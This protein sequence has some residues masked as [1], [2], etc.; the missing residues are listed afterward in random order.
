MSRRN[1][2]NKGRQLDGGAKQAKDSILQILNRGVL[3]LKL[4]VR[5]KG[6]K[7]QLTAAQSLET[8]L[9]TA[10]AGGSALAQVTLLWST[11]VRH[12]SKTRGRQTKETQTCMLTLCRLCPLSCRVNCLRTLRF[13]WVSFQP[14]LVHHTQSEAI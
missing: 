7:E 14:G 11:T 1:N 8:A 6:C 3:N 13:F 4:A 10:E 9:A 5:N 12:Y 2:N